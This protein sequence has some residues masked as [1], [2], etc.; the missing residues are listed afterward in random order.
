MNDWTKY[1]NI[2]PRKKQTED[3]EQI[4]QKPE[5]KRA[6]IENHVDEAEEAARKLSRA[7]YKITQIV[8]DKRRWTTEALT[9][10]K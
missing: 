10:D 8:C 1:Q 3:T 2:I 6:Y 5:Q 7:Y 9:V 4:N